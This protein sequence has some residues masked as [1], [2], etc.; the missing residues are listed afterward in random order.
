MNFKKILLRI[1]LGTLIILLFSNIIFNIVFDVSL[2]SNL[3]F[4]LKILFYVSACILFFYYVKPF[5]KKALYFGFYTLSPI[6]IFLSWLADGIFGGLLASVF[7]FF[8]GLPNDVK[9]ANDQIEVKTK[10]QGFL[11]SCCTY[12]V[13]EKK[14][15]L[16]EKKL[17]E[18]K[19][20]EGLDFN[21]STFEIQKNKVKIR[22]TLEDYDMKENHYVTKD[23]VVYVLLK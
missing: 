16:F 23:T 4:A 12:E 17:A 11:G 2:S 15:F 22:Y 3:R 21:K 1:H 19:I 20:E 14:C 5:K 13:I 8:F 7:L 6:F 9:F 10:F 18:F